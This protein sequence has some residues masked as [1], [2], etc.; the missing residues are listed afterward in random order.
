MNVTLYTTHCPKCKILETKL[1]TKNVQ[2][3]EISNIDEIEKAGFNSVPI[4]KVDDKV[5]KF[6]DANK[7]INEL[8]A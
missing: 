5:L 7:W 8:E 1:N 6:G 2:Y 4:L 3:T